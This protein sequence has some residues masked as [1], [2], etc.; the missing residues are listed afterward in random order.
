MAER[1]QQIHKMLEKEPNDTFLLYGLGMEYKKAGEW[2]KALESF[3]RVTQLDPMY[4]YAYH[5]RGLV[6]EAQGNFPAA[7]Q[8]YQEGMAAAEKKGDLHAREEI[9]GAL[10][11]IE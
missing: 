8:A 10:A 7:K 4:C 9:A 11:M 1:L 3:N 2:D 6:Y 5:Q